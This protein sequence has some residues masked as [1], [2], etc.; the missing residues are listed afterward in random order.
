MTP[1]RANVL[2][3]HRTN[4]QLEGLKKKTIKLIQEVE[5]EE[6]YSATVS[7]LCNWCDYQNICPKWSHLYKVKDLSSEKFLAEDGVQ[8]VN[9]YHEL[10]DKKKGIDRELN[11]VKLTLLNYAD[12]SGSDTIFGSDVKA[13]IWKKD[14]FKFPDSNDPERQKLEALLKASGKWDKV[15]RLDTFALQKLVGSD[16]FDAFLAAEIKRLGKKEKISRIYLSKL[17]KYERSD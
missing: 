3:S 9:K 4:E 13:K 7:A 2:E 11:E 17:S 10:S 16:E 15:S 8:L 5:V 1:L 12:E 14:T 6:E